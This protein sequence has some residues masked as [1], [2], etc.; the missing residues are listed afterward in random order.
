MVCRVASIMR[1]ATEQRI[2]ISPF[3]FT[4]ILI[5]VY[6]VYK[7]LVIYFI[8]SIILRV[9]NIRVLNIIVLFIQGRA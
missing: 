5:V 1:T 8:L 4:L 2:E 9:L 3:Y 6:I 7:I